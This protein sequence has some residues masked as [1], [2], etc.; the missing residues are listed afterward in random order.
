MRAL[1]GLALLLGTLS[2]A[3]AVAADLPR[4]AYLGLRFD[5]SDERGPGLLVSAVLPGSTAE[6]AGLR[7]GD[8]LTSVGSIEVLGAFDELRLELLRIPA[9]SRIPLR[10]Y[11]GNLVRRVAP[12]L[13]VLPTEQVP[14]SLVRYDQITVDGIRQ[15]LILSEPVPASEGAGLVFYLQGLDCNSLDYWQETTRPVKRL[16]DGWAEAGLAT[17]RLEKRG[18][19]DSEGEPC[20]ELDFDDELRGYSAAISRLSEL[21]WG[22]RIFLFGHGV[23]GIIA[24]E[25]ARD[26]VAGIMVYGTVAVPW[27]DHVMVD[28]ERRDRLSGLNEADIAARRMLHQDF[29]KGLLFEGLSPE[30]LLERLPDAAAVEAGQLMDDL[31]YRGRSVRFFEQLAAVIPARSWR[32]VWQP[33]L[34]LHGEFDWMSARKDHQTVAR[35]SGGKFLPLPGLG[36]D[37]LRY[38]DLE[39]SFVARGTGTFDGSLIEATLTWLQATHVAASADSR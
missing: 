2:T 30:V 4:R 14:G 25:L 38:Q 22:N 5:L 29:Q 37:F 16:I 35:L 11:H 23:G 32:R 13:G 7:P 10:W 24:P 18:V 6:R 20:S 27:Y 39:Q 12:S 8:R 1:I 33:V 17:A 26:E 21:G 19:G 31:H 3:A 15:R 9:G 34:T 36:H 28:L